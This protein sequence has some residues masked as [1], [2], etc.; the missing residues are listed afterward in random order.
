MA[1]RQVFTD[2]VGKGNPASAK[3]AADNRLKEEDTM[4][5]PLATRVAVGTGA[6]TL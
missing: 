1:R 4:L 2:S 3:F 6:E 5:F